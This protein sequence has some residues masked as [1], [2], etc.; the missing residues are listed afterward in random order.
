MDTAPHPVSAQ[1][2]PQHLRAEPNIRYCVPPIEAEIT[3]VPASERFRVAIRGELDIRTNERVV[4]LLGALEQLD[5]GVSV[6]LTAVEFADCGG[7]APILDSALR[8]IVA[9]LAPLELTGASR[10]V[11]RLLR[12]LADDP[13]VRALARR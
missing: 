13:G 2:R 12:I 1:K 4:A 8:R 9:G 3:V 5:R 10:V 7:L 6:D 11:R